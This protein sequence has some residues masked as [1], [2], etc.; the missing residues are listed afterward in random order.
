VGC[1]ELDESVRVSEFDGSSWSV[2]EL[3]ASTLAGAG[4]YPFGLAF[5]GSGGNATIVWREQGESRLRG[6]TWDGDAWGATSTSNVIADDVV[7][8]IAEPRNGAEAIVIAARRHTSSYL[9]EYANYAAYSENGPLDLGTTTVTGLVGFDLS[10][11]VLP[12][13]PSAASGPD[14]LTYG[15]NKDITLAPGS[16]GTLSVGNRVTLRLSAGM[17]AFESSTSDLEDLVFIADTSEGDVEIVFTSGNL[18]SMNNFRIVRLGD[19]VASLDILAGDLILKNNAAIECVV[20]VHA[21]SIDIGM[22]ADIVGHVFSS[23]SLAIDSGSLSLPAW[24]I[25]G[26]TLLT[27][28]SVEGLIVNSG[29]PGPAVPLNAAVWTL[30]IRQPV[31]VARPA[32]SS[33]P[34]IVQWI[35]VAPHDP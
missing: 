3:V 1:R 18:K 27:A 2:A 16:Y 7:E 32:P 10:D 29:V 12:V 11:V 22:N 34:R 28:Q 33:F 9:E 35:E 31:A 19:G 24:A 21:G 30:P 20:T 6:R 17:Y 14:D 25:A 5:E 26:T 23:D 8:I 13:P 4:D 15:H